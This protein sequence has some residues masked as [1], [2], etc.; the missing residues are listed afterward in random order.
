MSNIYCG[1]NLKNS[2]LLNKE[3]LPGS[4]YNC[5]RKGVGIGRNLPY[6]PDYEDDYD[7]ID[8]TRIYCGKSNKLP[9][10][11]DKLG[12][13][14]ECLRKGI[15]KGKQIRVK[16][17][18]SRS[19]RKPGRPKGSRNKRRSPRRKS[20]RKSHSRRKPGRPKG[21]RN[22]RRSPRRKSRR[23]LRSRRK[24]GRPKGSRKQT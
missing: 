20:K 5:L 9:T 1:N 17:G 24:P 12:S 13:N 2:R 16:K 22:K 23:D 8:K 4:R 21:S 15:G 3:L 11:Y 10:N 19:R 14:I 6:D 18:V 7:P